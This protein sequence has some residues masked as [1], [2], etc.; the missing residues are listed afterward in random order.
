[1]NMLIRLAFAAGIAASTQLTALAQEM[2]KQ[3]FAA[4]IGVINQYE[5][6][7]AKLAIEK[8]KNA[9]TVAYAKSVLAEHERTGKELAG[10][11]AQESVEL[12][13]KPSKETA[14]KITALQ[15]ASPDQF[16][17]SYFSAEVSMHEQA[18]KLLER[19]DEEGSGGPLNAFAHGQR[20]NFRMHYTRA[21][22]LSGDYVAPAA[23]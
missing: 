6:S 4:A 7:A 2:D 5:I 14:E 13:L 16:D 15:Q 1:M 9:K 8:S 3:A 11:A 18:M 17:A 21:Q 22:S 12:P 10:A 20:G 23:Q 19:Y